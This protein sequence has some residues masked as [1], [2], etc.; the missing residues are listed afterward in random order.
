MV[1]TSIP[2]SLL[3]WFRV[4]NLH[5]TLMILNR[6]MTIEMSGLSSCFASTTYEDLYAFITDLSS[7]EIFSLVA[8]LDLYASPIAVVPVNSAFNL[9][10]SATA[11]APP[12]FSTVP[13]P[14]ACLT[15][16]S[17]RSR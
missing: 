10:N 15:N 14:W 13:L 5:A 11:S 17:T 12:H 4:K 2:T 6:L 9:R 16:F 3:I 8:L 7:H 1:L